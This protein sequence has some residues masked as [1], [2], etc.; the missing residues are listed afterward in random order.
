[1]QCKINDKTFILK[2]FTQN[3]TLSYVSQ[4]HVA[5]SLTA[6]QKTVIKRINTITISIDVTEFYEHLY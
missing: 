4:H 1:M 2:V 3:G 6:N 5:A